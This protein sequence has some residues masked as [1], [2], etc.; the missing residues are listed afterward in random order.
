[1]TTRVQRRQTHPE[2]VCQRQRSKVTR[3][4]VASEGSDRGLC[5]GQGSLGEGFI[6]KGVTGDCV[7]VRGQRSMWYL[8]SV[9]RP[10]GR[11]QPL[12]TETLMLPLLARG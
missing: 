7:G 3:G 9:I 4:R 5:R 2:G 1:M 6:L 10:L 12:Q 11:L 8:L